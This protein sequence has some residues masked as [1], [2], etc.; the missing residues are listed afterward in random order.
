MIRCMSDCIMNR[1]C[2]VL[3]FRLL[4][5]AVSY[6]VKF[7]DYDCVQVSPE[8]AVMD[9]DEVFSA[10]AGFVERKGGAGLAEAAINTLT[11][12]LAPEVIHMTKF[13]FPLVDNPHVRRVANA[14]CPLG[15]ASLCAF[16][17]I[18]AASKHT[19][20][21]TDS[22][23]CVQNLFA[24]FPIHVVAGAKW[25]VFKLLDIF[26]SM[27]KVSFHASGFE[28]MN[29]F[30]QRGYTDFLFRP[31]ELAPFGAGRSV[32]WNT[33]LEVDDRG[34]GLMDEHLANLISS[35]KSRYNAF[36]PA[37][38]GIA[39]GIWES[40]RRDSSATKNGGRPVVL[41]SLLFGEAWASLAPAAWARWASLGLRSSIF[42]AM[43]IAA[44]KVCTTFHLAC[45]PAA[46]PSVLHKYSIAA[47]AMH[48][49]VD[50]LYCD[51][52]AVPVGQDPFGTLLEAARTP[53]LSSG[54][55][56]DLDIDILV[57]THNYDCLN[58]GLW[59]ARAS[60]ASAAFFL[61]LAEFLYEHWYEGDQRAFNAF[62][63]GNVSVSFMA[64]VKER[65]PQLQVAVLSPDVFA[66]T[67][68]FDSVESVQ[69]FHAYKLY[70]DEKLDFVRTL[71]GVDELSFSAVASP[72]HLSQWILDAAAQ[73]R[74]R[75]ASRN[76]LKQFV[77]PRRSTSC[78]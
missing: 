23:Q 19:E 14:Q 67:E 51:L 54:Y 3:L 46:K 75:E 49:G 44:S 63:T 53:T 68:G 47:L 45:I 74:V 64:S 72:Q 31:E 34:S 35:S 73:A 65:L 26:W 61:L 43:D 30:V 7:P 37:I 25:P 22:I 16:E 55:D 32:A 69:V 36:G 58:A 41:I 66:G 15:L 60:N 39:K 13:L 21:A 77:K 71:Y 52:D 4:S 33:W 40:V 27:N 10:L 6:H 20:D 29:R 18:A 57:S 5:Q 24:D 76:A 56:L 11:F 1:L 48:L 78:W 70:G 38:S 2:F 17:A 62:A 28:H 9:W 8:E 59:F 12:H 50:V 42:I